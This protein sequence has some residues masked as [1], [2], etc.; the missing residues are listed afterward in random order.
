VGFLLHQ[1]F[2]Y[3]LVQRIQFLLFVVDFAKDRY[4]QALLEKP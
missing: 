4:R 3:I 1:L 2:L